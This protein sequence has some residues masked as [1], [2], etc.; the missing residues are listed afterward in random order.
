MEELLPPGAQ[1]NFAVS[2]QNP[3]LD[4]LS[5]GLVGSSEKS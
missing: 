3:C 5:Q 4:F 1:G 2:T